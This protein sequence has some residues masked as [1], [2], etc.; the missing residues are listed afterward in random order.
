M[1]YSSEPTRREAELAA[2]YAGRNA[3]FPGERI[4]SSSPYADAGL[5]AHWRRGL[6]Q[7]L[8]EERLNIDAEWDAG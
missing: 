2:F 8:A 6:R 1:T 7:V 5:A 4:P 3:W